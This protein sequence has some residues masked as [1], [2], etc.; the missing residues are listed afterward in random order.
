MDE[1]ERS[2]HK[3]EKSCN[4]CN[5]RFKHDEDLE[6]QMKSKHKVV[7][8]SCNQCDKWFKH[9]KDLEEH[10]RNKHKGEMKDD[11]ICKS[12]NE[13]L[14]HKIIDHDWM[15]SHDQ[16]DKE[17]KCEQGDKDI[18]CDEELEEHMERVH[19][20]KEK[21]GYKSY[22]ECGKR[23]RDNE[24]LRKHIW[25]G[26]ESECSQCG[27]QYYCKMELGVHMKREN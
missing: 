10:M 16:C 23:L 26:H 3:V 13:Y 24:D 4:Q 15:G 8:R 7:E 2:I 12:G 14:N 21:E 6:D 22:P 25:M 27:K 18:T 5:K 1:H 19:V 17:Y 9:D 11:E 20:N